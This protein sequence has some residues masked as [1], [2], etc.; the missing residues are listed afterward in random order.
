MDL[1]SK[2]C[3]RRGEHI[4]AEVEVDGEKTRVVLAE[5]LPFGQ[6]NRNTCAEANRTHSRLLT[7]C[8]R[9]RRL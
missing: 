1:G 9:T 7:L 8:V 2:C 4:A 6:Q 5:S 3:L